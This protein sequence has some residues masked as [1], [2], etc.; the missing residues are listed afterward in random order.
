MFG[1]HVKR[2]A[3]GGQ[4]AERVGVRQQPR[5]ER[6]GT[7][8]MLEAVQYEHGRLAR[9]GPQH[10]TFGGLVRADRRA[11]NVADRVRDLFALGDRSEGDEARTEHARQLQREPGLAHAARAGQRHQPHLRAREQLSDRAQLVLAPERRLRMGRHDRAFDLHAVGEDQLFELAQL[12]PGHEPE[13]GVQAPPQILV[14]RERLAVA[15]E[16]VQRQHVLRAQTLTKRMFGDQLAQFADYLDVP[17]R[18][19]LGLEAQLQRRQPLFLQRGDRVRGERLAGETTERRA[20][21]PPQCLP[22]HRSGVRGAA[23]PQCAPGRL[24]RVLE[25]LAIQLSRLDA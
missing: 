10:G 18:G 11:Q 23:L 15:P 17:P 20:V 25:V 7:R 13:L 1:L 19:K 9:D 3:A 12:G 16:P 6:S 8:Q 4:D 22:Q 24:D 2:V 5:H 14:G 21:P